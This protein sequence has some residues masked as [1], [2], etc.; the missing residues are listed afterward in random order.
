[1]KLDK[2]SGKIL[3]VS[4]RPCFRLLTLLDEQI[5]QMYE[6]MKACKET[7]EAEGDADIIGTG[8]Q[9]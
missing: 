3:Q 7:G 4:P 5:V 1:V 2:M 6:L 8:K 9:P